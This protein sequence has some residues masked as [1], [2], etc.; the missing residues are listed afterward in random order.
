MRAYF[1]RLRTKWVLRRTRRVMAEML[2]QIR[3][4]DRARQR[5][6]FEQRRDRALMA[7][8]GD[9]QALRAIA[10]ENRHPERTAS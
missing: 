4:E 3:R 6:L 9:D 5:A 10:A 2:E 8:A 1:R 7:I